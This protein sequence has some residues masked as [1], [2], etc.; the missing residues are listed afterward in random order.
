LPEV[1]QEQERRR[2]DSYT[3]S[4]MASHTQAPRIPNSIQLSGMTPEADALSCRILSW[5]LSCLT[6]EM[7]EPVQQ[8]SLRVSVLEE[9]SALPVPVS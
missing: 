7:P 2:D 9:L 3:P 5:L 1:R 6:W 4:R 8:A